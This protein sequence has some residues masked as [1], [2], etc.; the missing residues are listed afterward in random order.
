MTEPRRTLSPKELA[1]RLAEVRSRQ[2]GGGGTAGRASDVP[3]SSLGWAFRIGVDLVSALV[4]GVG[5]GWLLDHSFGTMPMFLVLFF[6]LGAVAGALNV[7]RLVTRMG[8][9]SAPPPAEQ[10]PGPVRDET[11]GREGRD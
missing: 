7:W 11:R 6:F 9:V 2:G 8:M 3:R 1:E 10:A 5:I 4:V